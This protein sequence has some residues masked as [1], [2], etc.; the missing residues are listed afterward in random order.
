MI[1]RADIRADPA[2]IDRNGGMAKFGSRPDQI[3][4]M[5]TIAASE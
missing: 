1:G 2:E 5:P 3:A 4:D